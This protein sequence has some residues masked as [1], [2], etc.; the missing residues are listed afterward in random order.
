[1][2]RG[3]GLARGGERDQRTGNGVHAR[4]RTIRRR[5][6]SSRHIPARSGGRRVSGS[7]AT[8]CWAD[9]LSC[10]AR[11]TR[12]ISPGSSCVRRFDRDPHDI[13]HYAL[14]GHAIGLPK[15]D[16]PCLETPGTPVAAN[17]D[18]GSLRR[19]LAATREFHAPRTNTGV[20]D[21]PGGDILRH[22]RRVRGTDG[23]PVG[24]PFM[25]AG[26]F[27]HEWGHNAELTHGGGAGDPNC[28]PTYVS[29]M[30]YL[31]QLRGL[32]DDAGR[33]HLDFSR[34]VIAPSVDETGLADGVGR[35]VPDRLVRAAARQLSRRQ[36]T[37]AAKHCD[38]SL[39]LETDVPMVRIDA[40]TA[41]GPIDWKGNGIT[42]TPASRTTSTSTAARPRRRRQR[43]RAPQGLRRLVQHP[44]EPDRRAAQ[45]RRP[46]LRHERPPGARAAVP[47]ARALGLRPLGLRLGRPRAMG[48]R[49]RRRQPRRP[50]AGRLRPLGLR[51]LGFR[52]LGLRPA[53]LGTRRR[54]PRLSRRRRHVRR[55]T[56]T[57]PAASSTSKRPPIS[58]RRRRTSSAPAS[59]A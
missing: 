20:A 42:A 59:S 19:A 7:S 8:R 14:F 47:L 29:V 51:A 45:R 55:T 18:D 4:G 12:A 9:R 10:R 13:F 6:A 50:R 54:C 48:L 39:M 24:S 46:V 34:G 17:V 28:K 22:A 31:Y 1:M 35:A 23:K 30:N 5:S 38:G 43:G 15:S 49:Q 40:R 16:K 25:Q 41:A 27:M 56:R 26:T 37:A 44:N 21:F 2:I 36:A 52:P 53:D 32:L 3:A 57:T 33:P 11:T 58:R